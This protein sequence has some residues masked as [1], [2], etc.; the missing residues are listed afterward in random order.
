MTSIDDALDSRATSRLLIG[1]EDALARL[2]SM[3]ESVLQSHRVQAVFVEGEAGIGKT[4]TVHELATRARDRG[5]DVLVGRCI[6]Q[7]EQVLPYAPLVEILADLV[8]RDGP[9]AVLALAGPSGSELAR[10]VPAL[11]V[12]DVPTATRASSSRLFQALRGVFGGLSS[13]RP[14]VLVIE[15]LH[16]ADRST[17]EMLA[18]LTQQL[19]GDVLVVLTLRTDESPQ[20]PGIS[21]FVAETG[22]GADHRVVLQPLTREQQARQ[23]SDILGVPPVKD[24]LDGVY[25]RAEGNP[26]FAEELLALGTGGEVP[27]TVRDLL[28]ARLEALAPATRQLLRSACIVGRRVP[29]RLLEAIS[30]VSGE[31]LDRALRPAVENHVLVTDDADGGTYQFRHALLQEA[32]AGSILPGESRRMH[33]RIAAALVADPSVGGSTR[34]VAGR[35][36][37]H[38]FAAGEL[39]RALVAAVAAAREATEALAF[40][41]ALFHYDRAIGLLESVP[42]GIALLD[43]PLYRLLWRA[44]EVAHLAAHPARAAELIRAAIEAVDPAE[45]LHHGYLHERLGRYLWM[46]AEGEASIEAYTTAMELTPAEPPT[47]WRAAVVSGYSQI[48]M[49][50]SRYAEAI[51]LAREAIA[52]AQQVGA[53]SIEGHARNNLGVALARLGELDEGVAELLVARRI[54]D[55][56]MEDVDDVA[57]AI[58]NLHSVYLDSGHLREAADV[59]LE[60]VAVVETLGLQRRKGVWCRCDAA[61]SLLLLGENQHALDLLAEAEDLGP[62]GIDRVVVDMTWGQTLLRVGEVDQALARLLASRTGGLR[63]VDGQLVGPLYAALVEVLT[64]QGDLAGAL[65]MAEEGTGRL[66]DDEDPMFCVPVSAAAVAAAAAQAVRDPSDVEA[67]EEM[68]RWLAATEQALARWPG[69]VP[70]ATLHHE[71]ARCEMARGRGRSDAAA[72]SAL[73]AGW[74]QV[75]KPYRAAYARWRSAEA[76][77]S[78]T[79]DRAAA[80]AELRAA[81]QE[82]SRIG[83]RGLVTAVEDLARR[84]RIKL[85]TGGAQESATDN[86]FRLTPREREILLLVAEGLTDREIGTRLF[87]SHRTVGHHVSNLLAKLDVTRRSELTAYAHRSGLAGGSTVER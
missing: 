32:I 67:H 8:G 33:G 28:L 71:A 29:H 82:G 37:S 11:S 12:D 55:E 44:A 70:V 43:E 9:A 49:L 56:E 23:I 3:L 72:W 76:H 26:F 24:L 38:W 21:R 58:V 19:R 51:P 36:A 22:R 45:R 66:L 53:R 68:A 5:A 4:R 10:L 62:A 74:E 6:A 63:L 42:D 46:S 16:W 30:D 14:L 35:I 13:R 85:T 27:G 59:A 83:A 80:T 50:S 18:L 52:M 54:A 65:A 7:G 81:W 73:A 69:E 25:G 41:E 20:D 17:R 86:P 39:D 1:R 79:Q 64:W 77:L 2:E 31:G 87:I 34:F 78:V 15:D 84:S 47:S 60:G 75:P 61:Q 57:R 40:S 48:L